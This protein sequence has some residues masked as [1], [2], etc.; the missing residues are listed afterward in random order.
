MLATTFETVSLQ[1]IHFGVKLTSVK[2]GALGCNSSHDYK[3]KAQLQSTYTEYVKET[4]LAKISTKKKVHSS[5]LMHYRTAWENPK[6]INSGQKYHNPKYKHRDIKIK[7]ASNYVISELV[8]TKT[9][10]KMD[11]MLQT[12]TLSKHIYTARSDKSTYTSTLPLMQ[13]KKLWASFRN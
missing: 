9:V 10:C 4:K 2:L 11:P 5:L 12:C 3:N 13:K 8:D 1:F 7:Q 6:W